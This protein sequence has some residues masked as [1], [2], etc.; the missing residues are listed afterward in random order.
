MDI[1]GGK[2]TDLSGLIDLGYYR[3]REAV[4]AGKSAEEVQAEVKQMVDTV[5]MVADA[6]T[7]AAA[8]RA[9][10]A[11]EPEMSPEL[12]AE[13]AALSG[14]S[15]TQSGLRAPT[16]GVGSALSLDI[17]ATKAAGYKPI[18]Q[19]ANVMRA[20]IVS[21]SLEMSDDQ[22]AQSFEEQVIQFA[23]R[24]DV[25]TSSCEFKVSTARIECS[26]KLSEKGM[27]QIGAENRARDMDASA[28]GQ[29]LMQVDEEQSDRDAGMIFSKAI[30]L[31]EFESF[32]AARN[33][34]DAEMEMGMAIAAVG[35]ERK[36]D[37][38]QGSCSFDMGAL[39]LE[40]DTSKGVQP[41]GL[42]SKLINQVT[43]GE[44]VTTLTPQPTEPAAKPKRL[45]LS[46]GGSRSGQRCVGSFCD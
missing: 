14:A 32:R 38:P 5:M 8:A 22:V 16:G 6:E 28:S 31:V 25:P 35:F 2:V 45:E 4:M 37:L 44:E 7:A 29:I 9:A 11:P 1:T 3:G 40:C 39:R 23:E 26:E 17:K 36:H 27:A 12:Q 18:S 19:K 13:L 46:N 42:L 21:G 15:A 43:G 30:D 41:N 24:Y 10:N 33:A 34:T 20:K